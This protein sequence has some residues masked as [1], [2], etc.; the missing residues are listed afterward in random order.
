MAV[1]K[2]VTDDTAERR[3]HLLMAKGKEAGHDLGEMSDNEEEEKVVMTEEASRYFWCNLFSF[4]LS[5]LAGQVSLM[6]VPLG[7]K[8]PSHQRRGQN[9]VGIFSAPSRDAQ[10]CPVVRDTNS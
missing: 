5:M 8:S 3:V 10:P 2:Q 6:Y 4:F 9:Q 7:H 1:K